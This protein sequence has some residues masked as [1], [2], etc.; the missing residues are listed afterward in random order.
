AISISISIAIAVMRVAV[1]VSVTISIAIAIAVVAVAVSVSVSA[2]T[3]APAGGHANFAAVPLA[4]GGVAIAIVVA[5][6]LEIP[7][8]RIGVDP[9]DRG[10]QFLLRHLQCALG[11]RAGAV[12]GRVRKQRRN[13]GVVEPADLVDAA[14]ATQQQPRQPQRQAAVFGAY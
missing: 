2:V 3:I 12:A 10:D 8:G 11:E 4:F 13:A 7:G 1:P 5:I 6:V 9:A 14:A